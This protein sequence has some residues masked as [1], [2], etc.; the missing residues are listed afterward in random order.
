MPIFGYATVNEWNYISDGARIE[1]SNY[2]IISGNENQRLLAFDFPPRSTPEL[3]LPLSEA[4]PSLTPD[5]GSE[6]G[7]L[8]TGSTSADPRAQMEQVGIWAKFKKVRGRGKWG[9]SAKKEGEGKFQLVVWWGELETQ[10]KFAE[11]KRI[12]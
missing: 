5:T 10:C 3:P 6:D 7:E 12:K 9:R 11:S 4:V 8:R 1:S 2:I